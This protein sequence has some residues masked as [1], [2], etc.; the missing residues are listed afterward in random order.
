MLLTILILPIHAKDIVWFDGT[1]PVTYSVLTD[2]DLVV[3]TAL[4]MFSNDMLEVTEA[5]AIP[6]APSKATIHIYQLD[7][8]TD[9]E[10]Q[11]LAKMG[12]DISKIT[13]GH[14][15]F[16][17]RCHKKNIIVVGTNGRGAAY[18]ILELSR[19]AGVSPWI[20][21]GDVVPEM[22]ER[23]T[24]DSRFTTTQ[25]ASVEYRGI[26]LNDE[27]W[28]LRHWSYSNYEKGQFGQIGRRTYKRIFELL[29]R[30]RANTIWP[31]MH[32]NN[33]IW[34]AMHEKTTPFFKVKG[35]KEEADSFGIFV[36][37][38]HCEPLLRNN[39]SEWDTFRQGQFNY[40]TRGEG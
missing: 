20:W 11:D 23:L 29:L 3:E 32:E 17:I 1:N 38:S 16:S 21:W 25:S 35:A 5:Y 26:F 6:E 8:A 27:D 22:K 33:T 31:A 2:R 19:I 4:N 10:R 13:K 9:K 14:D 7:K 24:I 15:A 37:T 28:S 12:F 36:G 39:V 30:L 18:G 40:F 34:P